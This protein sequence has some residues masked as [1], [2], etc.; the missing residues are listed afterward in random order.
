MKALPNGILS[1]T[2]GIRLSHGLQ[3]EYPLCAMHEAKTLR[4][5]TPTLPLP[6]PSRG[7]TI[8]QRLKVRR[9]QAVDLGAFDPMITAL[10]HAPAYR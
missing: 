3:L 1:K 5:P 10:A 2:K 7:H 4:M 6:M 9:Q 8:V